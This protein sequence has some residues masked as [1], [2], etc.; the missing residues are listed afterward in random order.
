M[1]LVP[2]LSRTSGL[3]LAPPSRWR[4]STR[5]INC[6]APPSATMAEAL[7]PQSRQPALGWYSA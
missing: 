5:A 7:G 3:V 1:A 6:Q 4:C 2:L